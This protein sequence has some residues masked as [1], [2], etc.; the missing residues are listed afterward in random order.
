MKVGVIFS[1]PYLKIAVELVVR[2]VVRPSSSVTDVLW[3]SF[4]P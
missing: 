1:L 3:L 2:V 4:R